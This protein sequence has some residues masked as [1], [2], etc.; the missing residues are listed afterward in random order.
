MWE[1]LLTVS[2]IQHQQVSFSR[3]IR[4]QMQF[5]L[6]AP[7]LPLSIAMWMHPTL[8]ILLVSTVLSVAIWPCLLVP[9]N[10]IWQVAV[11]GN[12]DRIYILH[13]YSMLVGP[14]YFWEVQFESSDTSPEDGG[15]KNSKKTDSRKV[16]A[17][18]NL[19]VVCWYGQSSGD[20][21]YRR[22]GIPTS[23]GIVQMWKRKKFP[24]TNEC[25]YIQWMFRL[26]DYCTSQRRSIE[27]MLESF[28]Q[29]IH[30]LRPCHECFWVSIPITSG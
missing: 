5:A 2:G 23:S 27:G 9:L 12:R 28:R 10:G 14:T 6:L 4:L 3:V 1:R 15:T 13:L 8:S 19:S 22:Y 20:F 18:P 25:K 21:R 24:K 30:D 16:P 7:L 11:L 29:P 17:Y 26:E